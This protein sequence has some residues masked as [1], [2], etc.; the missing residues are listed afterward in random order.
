MV[1]KHN[2]FSWITTCFYLLR[3][4]D[5]PKSGRQIFLRITRRLSIRD[6]W[7]FGRATGFKR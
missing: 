5:G 6:L 4:E 7:L 1:S 2:L 3:I